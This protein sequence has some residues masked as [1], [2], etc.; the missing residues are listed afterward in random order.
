L[1]DP[2]AEKFIATVDC[3]DCKIWEV[4]HHT[5]PVDVGYFTKKHQHAGLKYE[6]ALAVFHDS[7][8]WVNGPFRGTAHDITVF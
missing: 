8:V 5:F 1:D 7:I 4:K 6:V 2:N 3:T